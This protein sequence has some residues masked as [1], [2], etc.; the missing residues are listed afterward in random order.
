M[1]LDKGNV[2]SEYGTF[3]HDALEKLLDGET[4]KE[5]TLKNWE[6]Y[7]AEWR[8]DP[9]AFQF[10]TSQIRDG[11]INNLTEY[12][13]NI[14]IPKHQGSFSNEKPVMTRIKGANGSTEVF[15]GYID[16]EYTDEDGNL[17]LVDYKT[18][19]KSSFSK[20]KLP[21]KSRQLRLYALGEHQTLDIPLDKIKCRFNM[22]KYCEV[23]FKQENGKWKTSVQ[24]RSKW[25]EKMKTKLTTK[26]RKDDDIQGFE[27]SELLDKAIA[28]N[29]LECMPKNIQDQFF[30][31]DYLIEIDINEDDLNDLAKEVAEKCRDIRSFE[32][33][34]NL[35]SY[36]EYT[37][38]YDPDN[39]FDKK[40]C[41]YHTSDYFKEKEGL[42]EDI[43]PQADLDKVNDDMVDFGDIFSSQESDDVFNELFG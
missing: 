23:H 32:A 3:T 29:S 42:L 25:V 41:G 15:V 38:P 19:S 13:D 34:P 1:N 17:V 12:F 14:T 4:T 24:E 6:T 26:L 11:Y 8:N 22:L 21:E 40:L 7:V 31:Q 27:M 20:S 28:A 33:I 10:D 5:Q 16:T 39:Y 2:Y 18:S 43:E 35:E 36:L 9:R 37:Y 30:I